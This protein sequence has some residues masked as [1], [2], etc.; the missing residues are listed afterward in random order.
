MVHVASDHNV[1][2]QVS[3][4]HHI[5]KKLFR[6]RGRGEFLVFDTSVE[7]FD[8]DRLDNGLAESLRVLLLN[9]NL[10]LRKNLLCV[11]IILFILVEN[12]GSA[13]WFWRRVST[14]A[15]QGGGKER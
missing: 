12:D 7:L 1:T 14:G 5:N 3:V 15:G 8:L 9:E 2:N 13:G 10:R 11:R 6:K 4:G